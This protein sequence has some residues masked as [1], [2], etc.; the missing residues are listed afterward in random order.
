VIAAFAVPLGHLS[1]KVGSELAIKFGFCVGA[2]GMWVL[3]LLYS[4]PKYMDLGLIVGALL[5]GI[6]FIVAFPAWMAHLTSIGS[7]SNRGTIVGAVST[8]QGVGAVIG[9]GL[10]GWLY[11]KGGSVASAFSSI[12]GVKLY[13]SPHIAHI[14]PFIASGIFLALSSVMAILMIKPNQKVVI[15]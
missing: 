12:I 8:A 4:S 13:D 11:D 2:I 1:D 3:V 7:I 10:G 5:L 14:T 6:G 9:T 15:S